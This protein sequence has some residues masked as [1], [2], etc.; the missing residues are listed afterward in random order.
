MNPERLLEHQLHEIGITPGM[1][2]AV[3]SLPLE[4]EPAH[5]ALRASDERVFDRSRSWAPVPAEDASIIEYASRS[6]AMRLPVL[7]PA[8]SSVMDARFSKLIN[9]TAS[10][11]LFCRTATSR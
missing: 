5:G 9:P 3:E 7:L 8:H 11:A 1:L 2:G 4:A 6:M 10:S